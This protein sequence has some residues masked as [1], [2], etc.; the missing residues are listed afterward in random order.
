MA[1]VEES[2]EWGEY[3]F[4]HTSGG[5]ER[6]INYS[7]HQLKVAADGDVRFAVPSVKGDGSNWKM[8]FAYIK[9]LRVKEAGPTTGF[10]AIE[11]SVKAV[12]M[13]ENGQVVILRDGVRYNVL[14]AKL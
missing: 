8:F 11:S 4:S 10:D 5:T 1:N 13:I 9:V 3:A 2:G 14:G 12:K 6:T 7:T